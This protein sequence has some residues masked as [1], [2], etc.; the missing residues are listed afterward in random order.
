MLSFAD[1][2]KSCPRC[3]FHGPTLRE[4]RSLLCPACS[5]EFFFNPAG[6]VGGFLF[7]EGQLLLGIRDRDPR[8]GYLDVPGG[9]I[10][11]EESAEAGL[12]RELQEE[13][14]LRSGPM[15]YLCSAPNLYPFGGV[16]YRTLDLFFWGDLES[17]EGL[18]AG[19][20]VRESLLIEPHQLD[21]DRFAFESTRQAFIHLMASGV[22]DRS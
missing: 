21:P 10:D 7:H 22:L 4:E 2:F 17:L 13:F 16:P 1:S 20:D 15:H 19:D 18:K 3:G 6:A 14:N 11:F 8:E 5:F 9:F 12:A